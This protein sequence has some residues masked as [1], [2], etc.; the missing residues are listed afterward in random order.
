MDNLK[1]YQVSHKHHLDNSMRYGVSSANFVKMHYTS[2]ITHSK[3]LQIHTS[4]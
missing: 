1:K 2:N 4:L 3:G